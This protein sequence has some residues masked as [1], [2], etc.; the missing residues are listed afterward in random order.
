MVWIKVIDQ[1]IVINSEKIVEI[2]WDMKY[3]IANFYAKYHDVNLASELPYLNKIYSK[4]IM[5]D[6]QV[7]GEKQ[8]QQKLSDNTGPISMTVPIKEKSEDE[9]K[10]EAAEY[11]VKRIIQYISDMSSWEVINLKDVI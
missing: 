3:P 2:T 11:V 7:L 5:A 9:L 6:V 1:N 10:N 8:Q 4:D